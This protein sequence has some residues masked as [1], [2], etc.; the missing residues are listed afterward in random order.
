MRRQSVWMAVA[1]AGCALLV[2]A[3]ETLPGGG[4]RETFEAEDARAAFVAA[5]CALVQ[6]EGRGYVLR[7]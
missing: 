3:G 6:V 4:Y 2:Q 1:A 5:A 7:S